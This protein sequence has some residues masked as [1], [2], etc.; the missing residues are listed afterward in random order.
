[1]PDAPTPRQ[2]LDAI[3]A[4]L[5]AIPQ[6]T[7]DA[8][9]LH[10]DAYWPPSIDRDRPTKVLPPGADPDHVPGERLA[11][12][13]G[14]DRS[15]AAVT[16][17]GQHLA[18]AH[19]RAGLALHHAGLAKRPPVGPGKPARG[20][21]ARIVGQATARRLRALQAW[22]QADMTDPAVIRDTWTATVAV[23][24]AHAALRDVLRDTGGLDE[25]PA[26]RRCVDCGKACED[27]KRRRCWSC[28]QSNARQARAGKTPKRRA[29]RHADAIEAQ[30]RRAARGEVAGECPL[31]RPTNTTTTKETA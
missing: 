26:E 16:A 30:K 12:G 4:A 31:P 23:L 13:V 9:W 17:A 18:V 5:A 2:T 27:Q 29:R 11:L 3:A 1:M 6:L 24:A 28:V 19:H 7:D 21:D 15:R 10:T 25:L 22:L 20:P 8:L 14:R